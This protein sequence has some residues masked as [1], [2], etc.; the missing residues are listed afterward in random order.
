MSRLILAQCHLLELFAHLSP[1]IANDEIIAYI[2]SSV[3][4]THSDVAR[5]MH[6][7]VVQRPNDVET[8]GTDGSDLVSVLTADILTLNVGATTDFLQELLASRVVQDSLRVQDRY[9]AAN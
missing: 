9:L 8:V 2:N 3:A 6:C 1:D 5:V 7:A 4:G